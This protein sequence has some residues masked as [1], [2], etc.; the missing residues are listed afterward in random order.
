M[1]AM[2]AVEDVTV[3]PHRGKGPDIAGWSLF[4]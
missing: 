3:E 1:T 2:G 4:P